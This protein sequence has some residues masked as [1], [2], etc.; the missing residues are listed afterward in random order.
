MC[1]QCGKYGH[2]EVKCP[3]KTMKEP[4]E[5][6]A[7]LDKD[8]LPPVKDSREAPTTSFGPWMVGQKVCWNSTRM[9]KGN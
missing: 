6:G 1:F 8:E 2:Q 9:I 4:P 5:V 7:K 3:M